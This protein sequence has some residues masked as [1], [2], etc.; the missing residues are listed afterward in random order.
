MRASLRIFLGASS[1]VI[2]LTGILV[3]GTVK[4]DAPPNANLVSVSVD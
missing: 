2:R 1:D 3:I 4:A